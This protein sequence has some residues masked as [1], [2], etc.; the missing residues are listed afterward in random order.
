MTR[1]RFVPTSA[2]REDVARLEAAGWTR[3]QA[4]TWTHERVSGWLCWEQAGNGRPAGWHAWKLRRWNEP[5]DERGE[6]SDW[7]GRGTLDAACDQAGILRP[8]ASP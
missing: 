5:P 7:E 4:G 2:P 8:A 6:C 1:A 3:D